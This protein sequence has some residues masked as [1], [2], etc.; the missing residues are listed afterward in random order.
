MLLV[1]STPPTGGPTDRPTNK[2]AYRVACTIFY[3][4]K[5]ASFSLFNE[6]VQEVGKRTATFGFL[7][8]FNDVALEKL[9]LRQFLLQLFKMI[10]RMI[11]MITMMVM[12]VMI[13]GTML[14]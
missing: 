13:M 4:F 7:L 11:I 1:I 8:H 9:F 2:G 3:D 6:G 5:V 14:M 12:R 10:T